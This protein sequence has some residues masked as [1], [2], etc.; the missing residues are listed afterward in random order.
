MRSTRGN[1]GRYDA[2]DFWNKSDARPVYA[3]RGTELRFRGGLGFEGAK[4]VRVPIGVCAAHLGRSEGT[5]VPTLRTILI[6]GQL[7]PHRRYRRLPRCAW[8]SRIPAARPRA[9]FGGGL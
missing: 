6:R 5:R 8:Q 2:R 3:E 4:I 1:G 7:P 9:M